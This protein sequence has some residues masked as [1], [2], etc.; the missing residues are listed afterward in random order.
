M[1]EKNLLTQMTPLR[2]AHEYGVKRY[3]NVSSVCVYAPGYNSPAVEENGFEGRPTK[4]NE[5]YSLSK[6]ISEKLAI[7]YANAGLHTVRVRP[8]NVFGPGDW[9]DGRAH[10]IPALIKKAL[11][12]DMIEVNGT[13]RE[14]RE[15]IYVDDVAGLQP[16]YRRQY[17]HFNQRANADY[18]VRDRHK[19]QARHILREVGRG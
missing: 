2:I 11:E 6:R 14:V 7:W 1:L 13:G 18:S 3:L 4:A 17:C 16:W 19:R 12:N 9:F 15:F 10:V 5:A 8:T